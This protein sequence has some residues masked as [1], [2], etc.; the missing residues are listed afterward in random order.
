VPQ[1][2]SLKNLFINGSFGSVVLGMN[3]EKVRLLLG[4]ATAEYQYSPYDPDDL[5]WVYGNIGFLFTNQVLT[6]IAWETDAYTYE[7]Y[8]PD[9]GLIPLDPWIVW[10]G[11]TML[12]AERELRRNSIDFRK[13]TIPK[14]LTFEGDSVVELITSCNTR[15]IFRGYLNWHLQAFNLSKRVQ[16]DTP[17]ETFLDFYTY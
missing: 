3:S 14:E 10:N 13:V 5:V 4:R 11:L 17:V 1:I 9:A 15:L 6:E 7:P 8:L 2:I 16:I 12:E